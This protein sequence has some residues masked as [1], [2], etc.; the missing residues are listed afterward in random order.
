MQC[1]RWVTSTII[2]DPKPTSNINVT[3]KV[4]QIISVDMIGINLRE[5]H[6]I[7]HNAFFTL[8]LETN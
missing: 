3:L 6:W 4:S 5:L 7:I 8:A 1:I 2:V